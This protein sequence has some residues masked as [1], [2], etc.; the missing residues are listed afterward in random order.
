MMNLR[1]LERDIKNAGE[2]RGY[3]GTPGFKGF[4]KETIRTS[5]LFGVEG[6]EGSFGF[7]VP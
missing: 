4:G 7:P 5:S 1:G 2:Y 6:F 3:V